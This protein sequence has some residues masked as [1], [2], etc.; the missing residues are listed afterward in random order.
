MNESAN[1][2][3]DRRNK[4]IERYK[5]QVEWYERTKNDARLRFY[6]CQTLVVFLTGVTP[7]VILATESKLLQASFPALASILAGV[8]GIWQ[9]QD[10]WQRR[11]IALEA[12][13]SEFV[14]FDTRSGD[15]Y[16]SPITEDQAIERFVLKIEDIVGNEVTEWRRQRG[17]VG[18]SLQT[19]NEGS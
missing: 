10:A 17:K 18:T 13:K 1:T 11:A 14:K 6:W 16:R 15:D 3:C 4:A 8:L 12:L 7:L 2:A 9:F 5:S 19:N